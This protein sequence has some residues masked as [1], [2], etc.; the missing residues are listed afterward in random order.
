MTNQ[1][2]DK[3]IKSLEYVN[4]TTL[5]KKA[6]TYADILRAIDIAL[7]EQIRSDERYWKHKLQEQAKEIK[8][9]LEQEANLTIN[10][11]YSTKREKSKK[12]LQYRIAI[13][14][15][16]KFWEKYGVKEEG[17]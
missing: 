11:I 13:S 7:I 5:R 4:G 12:E 14:N 17:K 16:I 10:K 2:R 3:A 15:W 9:R 8:A 1:A 6:S